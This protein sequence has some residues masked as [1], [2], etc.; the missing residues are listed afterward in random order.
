MVVVAC[1]TATANA[2]P[3]LRKELSPLPVLGV[4]EPGAE[5]AVRVSKNGRIMV[6]ATEA[7]IKS[8]VYT[9]AIQARLP[10]AQISSKACTLFVSLAEEGLMEGDLVEACA[11]YYLDAIF[12]KNYELRPD[13]MILGCTH[14]PLLKKSLENVVGEDVVVVDPAMTV[15]SH[16]QAYLGE[17]KLLR[18]SVRSPSYQF[19]TTDNVE[20]FARTGTLFLG[21]TLNTEEIELIDL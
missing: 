7:T 19:L 3:V 17:R 21:K 1:N 15:A 9:Q 2:L 11:H 16:V 5:E 18:S 8:G 13:T 6:I 20:R 14:F 4:V 10:Q 12:Q